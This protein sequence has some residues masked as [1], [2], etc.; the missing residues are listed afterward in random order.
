MDAVVLL[1]RIVLAGV[2]GLAAVTK[3]ADLPGSRAA[4]E[5]FG[6]PKRLAAPAGIALPL[7]ELAIAILLLPVGTAWW[8]ALAGLI[9]MLAFIAGIGYTLSQGRTPD[10]HC[11]GQVYSEPVGTST[12]VRNS[13]F[14]ALTALLVVQGPNGQGASLTGWLR[15]V[16]TTDRV[17]LILAGL[18]L[19]GLVAISWLTFQ[20]LQQN[21]RLLVRIEAL[22]GADAPGGQ[23]ADAAGGTDRSVAGLPAGSTAPAFSLARLDGETVTLD[24][25][26]AGGKPVVLIFTDPG[27]GPCGALMPELGRWQQDH[28]QVLTLALI[29]RG[30]REANAARAGEH[31]ISRVLLQ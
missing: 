9:L 4:M 11:F 8:G 29:S 12:L 15:D 14:A 17:L 3:M 22:E 31:G 13:A 10:C 25:L 7:I 19:G 5:G 18:G 23:T 27:C 1:V 20:L 30:A 26:R 21:G 28:A 6:L 16:S 24:S 2:F